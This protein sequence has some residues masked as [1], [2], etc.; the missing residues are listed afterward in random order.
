[1]LCAAFSSACLQNNALL[2]GHM[3][4]IFDMD[5]KTRLP[6]RFYGMQFTLMAKL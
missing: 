5:D 1:V 6:W 2:N 3:E 4:M